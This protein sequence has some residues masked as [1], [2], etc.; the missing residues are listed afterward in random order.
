MDFNIS[1]IIYKSMTFKNWISFWK[2]LL[3]NVKPDWTIKTLKSNKSLKVL[4]HSASVLNINWKYWFVWCVKKGF[5]HEEGSTTSNYY[6]YYCHI[7]Q[8]TA[9]SVSYITNNFLFTISNEFSK[10]TTNCHK[11]QSYVWEVRLFTNWTK[12]NWQRMYR[13]KLYITMRHLP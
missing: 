6:C 1:S 3:K 7:W 11:Y 4:K 8:K 12:T 9:L 13:R 2:T 10:V 5:P